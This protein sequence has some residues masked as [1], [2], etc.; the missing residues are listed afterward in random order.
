MLIAQMVVRNES[1]RHLTRVLDDLSSYVDKIVITD[2]C[3]TD[4]TVAICKKYTKHVF[5]L[6]ESLFAVHEGQLRQL[7]LDNLGKVANKNDWILAID[8][9]EILWS[10]KEPLKK[11]LNN[12]RWDVMGLEFI[13]MWDE[14]NYRIDG[15]WAPHKCTKLYRF[16]RDGKI[17]DRVLACGS[18]PTYVEEAIRKN[19]ILW[20]S[21]LKIQHLGYLR[22]EDKMAKYQRYME[23]DGGKFH[24][25]KH[26]KSILDKKV[27]LEKWDF[28][29]L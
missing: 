9:D 28:E 20:D 26:L 19:R 18:E 14:E 24:N 5:E 23:I 17:K 8:A 27:K 25:P 7:A 13:N 12:I 3:S 1:S 29:R 15:T 22:D 11:L 6:S 21:G 2:D 4:D 16:R 10:T